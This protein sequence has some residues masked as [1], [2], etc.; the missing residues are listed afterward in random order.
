MMKL[1]EIRPKVALNIGSSSTE[2]ER[3]KQEKRRA[4]AD[5]YINKGAG[6]QPGHVALS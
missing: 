3:T 6:R 1:P 5:I 4:L 2:K